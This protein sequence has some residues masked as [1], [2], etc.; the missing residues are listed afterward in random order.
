MA[1]NSCSR[2]SRRP[3]LLEFEGFHEPDQK[4]ARR[5]RGRARNGAIMKR[6]VV[7]TILLTAITASAA[8]L[9]LPA[10]TGAATTPTSTPTRPLPTPTRAS[11]AQHPTPTPVPSQ[12]LTPSVSASPSR[13]ASVGTGTP[14]PLRSPTTPQQT[15]RPTRTSTSSGSCQIAPPERPHR[16]WPIVAGGLVS[17]VGAIRF[18]L[19]KTSKRNKRH[20]STSS[21]EFGPQPLVN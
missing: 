3:D 8:D 5:R 12:H 19:R 10:A 13:S 14:T 7:F 21:D 20:C 16:S 17:L 11:T 4:P 9:P 15:H 2:P 1:E 6:L 18:V